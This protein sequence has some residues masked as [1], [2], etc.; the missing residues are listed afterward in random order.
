MKI[1]VRMKI[2][3]CEGNQNSKY[4]IQIRCTRAYQPTAT[5]AYNNLLLDGPAPTLFQTTTTTTYPSHRTNE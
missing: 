3:I 4:P 5:A 1:N 2:L